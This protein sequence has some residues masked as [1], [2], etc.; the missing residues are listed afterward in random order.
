MAEALHFEFVSPERLLMSED[1]WQVVVPGRDGDFAVLPGHAPVLSSMRPGMVSVTREP[2]GTEERYFV[3][4]GFA[5]AAGGDLTILAETAILEA[6]LD[7][8]ALAEAI[9]NAEEDL[10][11]AKDE[12]SRARRQEALDHLRQIEQAI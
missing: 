5:E 8:E 6:D 7:R 4:G 10:A 11:D 9:R 12:D 2:G 1:V 3:R